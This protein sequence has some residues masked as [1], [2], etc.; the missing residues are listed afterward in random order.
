[1]E[2]MSH[3]L[4][5]KVPSTVVS[6]NVE[7]NSWSNRH[8]AVQAHG[9][10]LRSSTSCSVRLVLYD[11]FTGQSSSVQGIYPSCL[12]IQD[13]STGSEFGG[14]F[15]D[16][17]IQWYSPVR[18]FQTGVFDKRTSPQYRDIPNIITVPSAHSCLAETC[19]WTVIFS[20]LW[21]SHGLD[22]SHCRFLCTLYQGRI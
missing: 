4:Y 10:P 17:D 11:V 16:I 12:E 3:K 19:K 14:S 2:S 18:A 6:F 13:T 21:Y 1:M 9:L 8:L 7:V 20:Q 5:R 15:M 22:N